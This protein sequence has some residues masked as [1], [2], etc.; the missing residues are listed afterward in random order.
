MAVVISI[1]KEQTPAK[2]NPTETKASYRMGQHHGA[3][4][5]QFKTI[6]SE[7]REFVGK[8]SQTLQFNPASA[9]RLYT[10]LRAEF[11]FKD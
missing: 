7:D 1:D 3:P 9:H 2:L 11:G 6:G 10:I 5:I 8:G 4:I